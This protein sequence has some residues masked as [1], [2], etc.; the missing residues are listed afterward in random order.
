LRASLAAAGQA[1][2]IQTVGTPPADG[3]DVAVDT[4]QA[5]VAFDTLLHLLA[6]RG[7]GRPVA[8]EARVRALG[9]PHPD[10]V[11]AAVHS[12]DVNL[13]EGTLGHLRES[14]LLNDDDTREVYPGLA[15]AEA[16]A[17]NHGGRLIAR[18]GREGV[19]LG[20]RL[21]LA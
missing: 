21:P 8:V 20:L 16:V 4:S 1:G 12:A 5:A 13:D 9:A 19:I 17:R 2:R 3:P 11:E 18:P 15:L 10:A 6:A 14:V 7:G